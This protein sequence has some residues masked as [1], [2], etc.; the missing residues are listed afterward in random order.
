MER[1][2][3]T[4]SLTSGL[5]RG[6][7]STSLP[8]RFTYGKTSR[9]PLYWSGP[10]GPVWTGTENFTPI[11]VP[12][13]DRPVRSES[14]YRVHYPG[15]YYQGHQI[16]KMQQRLVTCRTTGSILVRVGDSSLLH[17]CDRHR[18]QPSSY[19]VIHNTH[20]R[21]SWGRRMRYITYLPQVSKRRMRGAQSPLPIH[22]HSVVPKH[23]P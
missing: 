4:L 23:T 1:Y 10:R 8:G 19:P 14:L 7:W 9:Y 16:K 17:R 3:S 22:L 13:P 2:S 20:Y 11:G 12:T 21:G 5:D 15:H 18:D 6:R